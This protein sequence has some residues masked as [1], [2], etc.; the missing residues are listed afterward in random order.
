[1]KGG[2]DAAVHVARKFL[3][4]MDSQS[5]LVK[6]DFENA[7]NYIRRNHMQQ[8]VSDLVPTIYPFC[9][10]TILIPISIT[11]ERPVYL[12]SRS[13]TKGSLGSPTIQSDN[14]SAHLRSELCI[15]YMDD[16]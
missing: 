12:L 3:V 16:I 14:T 11:L 9:T 1:M 7:F 5:A 15:M 13:S 8:A 2:A 10:L 4:N 6:L